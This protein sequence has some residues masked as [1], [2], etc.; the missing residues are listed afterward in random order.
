MR[1]RYNDFAWLRDTL[2]ATYEGLFIPSIPATTIFSSKTTLTGGS[3]TDVNGDFVKNRMLQLHLFVQQLANIPFLRTDPSLHSF[4]SVQNEKEFKQLTE[5]PLN[6]ANGGGT[7]NYTNVGLSMWLKLVDNTQTNPEV[8]NRL[9]GD[10]KRQL[11][12]LGSTLNQ[13]DAECRAAGKKA[14]VSASAFSSLV[15]QVAHWGAVEADLIDPNRNEYVDPSG[16]A[17]KA[18]LDALT[19]GHQH[20]AQSIAVSGGT[21]LT[22]FAH[23]VYRNCAHLTRLFSFFFAQ[24]IPKV[25]ARLL[26]SNVQFQLVQVA[27]FKEHLQIRD[28]L[29][30]ELERAE[31]EKAKAAEDKQRSLS[32]SQAN[33]RQ[34]MTLMFQKGPGELV[35]DGSAP[36]PLLLLCIALLITIC[37]CYLQEEILNKKTE[38]VA[39]LQG[40]VD[41]LTKGLTFCEIHRFNKDRLS[42]IATMLGTLTATHL[43]VFSANYLNTSARCFQFTISTPLSSPHPLLSTDGT[44]DD[45]QVVGG[46]GAGRGGGGPLQRDGQQ[47]RQLRRARRGACLQR[48]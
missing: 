23:L 20:W 45:E 2:A 30:K 28:A 26:L 13:V 3:K 11:D 40:R 12:I 33:K 18:H 8:A 46:G 24:L 5:A 6:V 32:P 25:M 37:W 16:K 9:V 21:C 29:I 10:F 1:R 41:R 36:F 19:S 31:R 15:D 44:V 39:Q 38:Q 7:D 42:S 34:S 47:H 43:Q 4:L 27:R 35:S 22:Y 17:K 14:V 48:R